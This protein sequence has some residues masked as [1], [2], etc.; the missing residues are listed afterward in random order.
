LALIKALAEL[1]QRNQ[2]KRMSMKNVSASKN[3]NIN[4]TQI[5]WGLLKLLL[6]KR[7]RHSAQI[8]MTKV[9]RPELRAKDQSLS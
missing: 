8:S 3:L 5:I 6:L 4:R 9:E 2:V 1:L 7:Q